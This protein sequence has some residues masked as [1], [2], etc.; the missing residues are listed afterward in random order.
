MIIFS[1]DISF[2]GHLDGVGQ[3]NSWGRQTG[4][5]GGQLP[6]LTGPNG[7]YGRGRNVKK[8]AR[9]ARIPH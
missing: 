4:P 1:Q 8:L 6:P 7:A 3:S 2:K 9:R 5:W